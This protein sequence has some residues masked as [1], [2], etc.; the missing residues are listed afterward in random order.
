MALLLLLPFAHLGRVGAR[1][2]RHFARLET[3]ASSVIRERGRAWLPLLR[4]LYA[5]VSGRPDRSIAWWEQFADFRVSKSGYIALQ[6]Q[7]ALFLAGEYDKFVTDV[8]RVTAR[9]VNSA[10]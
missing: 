1:V 2:A 5:M 10:T 7:N 3:G 8:S 4:A 9:N 6:R